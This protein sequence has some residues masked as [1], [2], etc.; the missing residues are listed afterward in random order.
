MWSW[1]SKEGLGGAWESSRSFGWRRR[2]GAER[3][4]PQAEGGCRGARSPGWAAVCVPGMETRRLTRVRDS[5]SRL[6]RGEERS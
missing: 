6:W 1:V 3:P 2:G 4:D 5:G